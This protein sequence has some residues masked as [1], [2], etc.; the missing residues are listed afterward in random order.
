MKVLSLSSL[1]CRGRWDKRI[2]ENRKVNKRMIREVRK[3]LKNEGIEIEWG[4]YF[5]LYNNSIR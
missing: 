4:G 2:Q 1:H 5:E 3:I